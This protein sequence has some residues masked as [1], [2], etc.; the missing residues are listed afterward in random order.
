MMYQTWHYVVTGKVQG[1][2]YRASTCKKATHLGLLGWVQNVANG[3]V[4]LEAF[5]APDALA[6]LELWLWRGPEN[7]LVRAVKVARSERQPEYSVFEV[8]Y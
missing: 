5:G 7:A 3:D 8:R 2:Y 1:V 6:E 4:E